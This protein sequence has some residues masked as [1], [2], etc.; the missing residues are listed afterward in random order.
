MRVFVTG[1]S[2]WIGSAVVPE[3]LS[4]GHHVTGL[5]RSDK[6]AA[7][8]EASGA[9]SVRGSI[10]DLDLLRAAAAGS[11]A[12]IHLAFPVELALAGNI[13]EAVAV[14]VVT[15]K[16]LGEGLRPGGTIAVASATV[17]LAQDGVVATERDEA[18]PGALVALRKPSDHAAL[19]LSAHGLRPVVVRLPPTSHGEGD[20][21]FIPSLIETARNCG[22]SGYPADGAARWSAVHVRDTARLFRIAVETEVTGYLH[23]VAEEGI[24]LREI[25]EA[26][27]RHLDM[28]TRSVPVDRIDEHFGWVAPF[29]KADSPV[30]SAITRETCDWRPTELSLLDDLG[31]G[32]YFAKA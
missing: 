12:V 32:H 30:S 21:G 27:G 6:S 10:E 5:A 19:A 24:S 13:E 23:A 20:N 16:T 8:I 14:D 17:G 28:R 11:D 3:L 7:A 1:A 15:I 31:E 25:A 4:A 2:G 22:F 18:P 9:A 26:I 29:L